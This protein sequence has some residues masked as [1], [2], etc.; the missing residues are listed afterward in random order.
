M[1]FV[2]NDKVVGILN[3]TTQKKLS[4]YN[5]NVPT[6]NLDEAW[7][8]IG[9]Q[10]GGLPQ[11]GCAPIIVVVTLQRQEAFLWYPKTRCL[12]R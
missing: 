2:R 8:Y 1:M 12:S 9:S 7:S 6:D 10:A 3:I 11:Q 4:G 5:D